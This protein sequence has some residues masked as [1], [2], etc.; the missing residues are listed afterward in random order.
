VALIMA[1]A[2]GWN[3][4][5]PSRGPDWEPAG[6]PLSIVAGS[7]ETATR[8]LGYV[9]GDAAFE[10][11]A[12]PLGPDLNGYGLAYRA[13][14]PTHCYV[15]AVGSDGYYAVLRVD[16]GEEMALVDWQQFPHVRR[17]RQPNRLRV[18]CAGATCRFFINEEY[19]ATV[20]DATWFSGDVG[21]WVHSLEGTVTVEFPAARVWQPPLD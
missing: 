8:L 1:L 5:R 14:D 6:L 19:A 21:L 3:S 20:E 4:P 13:Q 2:L 17:H 7:G 12:L 15:F 10:V 9:A 18:E 11:E 16:G